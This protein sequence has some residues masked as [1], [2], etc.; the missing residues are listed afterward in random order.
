MVLPNLDPQTRGHPIVTAIIAVIYT[1]FLIGTPV[2]LATYFNR[3]WRGVG[4]VPNRTAYVVWIT[5]E[6]IAGVALLGI[7]A[8][9]TVSL[10]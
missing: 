4:T 3:A 5:L 10:P 1:Q 2:A 8:Y 9:K 7:L 6:S